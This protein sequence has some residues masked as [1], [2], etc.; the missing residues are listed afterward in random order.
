LLGNTGVIIQV[1][2]G[3]TR[4]AG[5][6]ILPFYE[7][8]S[9]IELIIDRFVSEI[10]NSIPLII[11]TTDNPLDDAI[12]NIA[13][14]KKINLYRGS[15]NDVLLRFMRASEKFKL[16]NIIRICA[17]NPLFDIKGTIALTSFLESGQWDYIGYKIASNNPTILTHSGFWGEVVTLTALK[18]A[19]EETS[20]SVYRE[21]VTKYIHQ[22]PGKFR[23]KLVDAPGYLFFRND[24]RLTVDT[25]EDFEL[26]QEIYKLLMAE[27]ISIEP[28][29]VIKF[30]DEHPDFL[31]RMNHPILSV[32]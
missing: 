25:K 6:M 18:K 14:H 29:S 16:E 22:H 7:G 26:M 19:R 28:E 2:T 23:V 21:H 17:D 8:Q 24:I 1:R 4:L 12:E 30:I 3:S 15:E 27:K 10:S 13:R 32:K 5:K 9:M 20:E 31:V 11:A